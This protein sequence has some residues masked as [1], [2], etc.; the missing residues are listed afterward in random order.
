[1]EERKVAMDR[2]GRMEQL[3]GML[4]LFS[5][6]DSAVLRFYFTAFRDIVR[7]S[8]T[9]RKQT[10]VVER[11]ARSFTGHLLETC[12]DGWVHVVATVKR[13]RHAAVRRGDA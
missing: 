3:S 1:M 6:P 2:M 10:S 8:K 13:E 9:K 5:V 12:V 7:V 4:M 11:F